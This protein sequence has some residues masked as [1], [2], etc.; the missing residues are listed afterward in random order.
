MSNQSAAKIVNTGK[1]REF[2]AN[3]MIGVKSGDL[4]VDEARTIVK[5]AEKINESFYAELKVQ[6]LNIELSRKV[7][8]L[9]LLEIG[10]EKGK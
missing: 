5:L 4:R 9:G 1:L 6:Q 7:D 8:E 3:M 2:L 10:A